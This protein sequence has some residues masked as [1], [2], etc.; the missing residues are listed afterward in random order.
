MPKVG[1]L[2]ATRKAPKNAHSSHLQNP[3]KYTDIK[4]YTIA[5]I[6]SI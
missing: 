3:S 4:I 6:Y 2:V 1:V 5:G